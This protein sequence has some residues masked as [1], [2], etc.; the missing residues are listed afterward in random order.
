MAQPESRGSGRRRRRRRREGGPTGCWRKSPRAGTRGR[1]VGRT[2]ERPG[3]ARADPARRGLCGG[4][5][6]SPLPVAQRMREPPGGQVWAPTQSF[7]RLG[8]RGAPAA[9]SCQPPGAALASS[10]A[11]PRP[12]PLPGP[13][14]PTRSAGRR[15]T[16]R[17]PA[18]LPASAGCPPRAPLLLPSARARGGPRARS[19][20]PT[21]LSRR[22][23][24]GTWGGGGASAQEARYGGGSRRGTRGAAGGARAHCAVRRRTELRGAPLRSP[25]RPS[26][27]AS[28]V[29]SS[30]SQHKT[31][32][33]ATSASTCKPGLGG[34]GAGVVYWD[35]FW[36]REG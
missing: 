7:Q 11:R 33:V 13:R 23:G 27:Q 8:S 10:P 36:M 31:P 19:L 3:G 1:G 14:P 30:V 6:A 16:L 2:G 21:A 4:P 32:L 12:R 26:V 15:L 34:G 17:S 25:G 5:R 9:G 29:V 35:T 24:G 28:S 18:R 20:R 22:G